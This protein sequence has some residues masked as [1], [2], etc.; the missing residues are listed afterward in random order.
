MAPGLARTVADGG[1]RRQERIGVKVFEIKRVTGAHCEERQEAHL[2]ATIAFA[3]R[4]DGIQRR[5]KTRRVRGKYFPRTASKIM[6]FFSR[7]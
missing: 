1:D 4:M 6:I 2:R 3:K 7:L 5:K